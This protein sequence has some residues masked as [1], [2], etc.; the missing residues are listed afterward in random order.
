ML[1]RSLFQCRNVGGVLLQSLALQLLQSAVLFQIVDSL[2]DLSASCDPF[3]STMPIP[4]GSSEPGIWPTTLPFLTC[5]EVATLTAAGASITK[6]SIW[7]TSNACAR[8]ALSLNVWTFAF[9][10]SFA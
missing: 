6:A 7:S 1:K 5:E 9:N 3:G 4:C 2:S 8:F 10:S